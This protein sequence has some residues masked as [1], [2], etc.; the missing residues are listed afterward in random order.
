MPELDGWSCSSACA[1]IT[2]LPVV[3]LSRPRGELEAVRGLR[4]GADD[5]VRKPFGPQELLARCSRAAAPRCRLAHARAG[6]VRRRLGDVPT[7]Q[8]DCF[9][10]SRR[11]AG[12]LTPLPSFDCCWRSSRNP[13]PGPVAR[14]DPRAGLGRRCRRRDRQV[15][16]YVGYLRREAREAGPAERSDRDR[17][18][19]RLP[20]PAARRGRLTRGTAAPDRALLSC[21]SWKVPST[22]GPG[23]AATAAGPPTSRCRCTTRASTRSTP[24]PASGPR[25]STDAVEALDH[26]LLHLVDDLGPLAG[27]GIDLVDAL[28]VHLH[29]EVGGPAPVAA[30]P[31]PR[32]DGTFHGPHRIGGRGPEL[33]SRAR[34]Q[35]PPPGGR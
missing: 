10:P 35:A 23:C 1:S 15:K 25:S 19:L 27:L 29:L 13:G 17:A 20:L 21:G 30:Q 3:M 22:R 5:Y 7:L 6:D 28:V 8:L 33:L 24:S 12:Q 2:D 9:T 14:S 11:A 32:I 26:R 16:L 34:P 31:G 4:A 18:R